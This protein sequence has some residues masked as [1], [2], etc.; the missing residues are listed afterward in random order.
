MCTSRLVTSW[1]D[2]HHVPYIRVHPS[3]LFYVLNAITIIQVF[4]TWQV[5]YQFITQPNVPLHTD[6]RERGARERETEREREWE[7]ERERER[8]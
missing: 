4:T 7:R 6:G 3:M 5:Y 2:K 8:E 1:I